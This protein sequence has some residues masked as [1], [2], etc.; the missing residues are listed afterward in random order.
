MSRPYRPVRELEA[1]LARGELES[2]IALAGVIARERREPLE[3]AVTA[4]F[5]PLVAHVRPREFDRWALRWLE[6][7]CQERR[8]GAS[9]DD[10]VDVARALA[11]IPVDPDVGLAGLVGLA[12]PGAGRAAA[13]SPGQAGARRRR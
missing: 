2:A 12:A 10:A 1:H 3:L 11:A 6:R 13:R 7:W 5:L 8:D 4:R 9:I